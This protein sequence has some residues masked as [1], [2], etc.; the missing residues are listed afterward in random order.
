MKQD[1]HANRVRLGENVLVKPER[2][3]GCEQASHRPSTYTL[4]KDR[5]LVGVATKC[6][7]VV[8]DP[9]Q[10]GGLIPGC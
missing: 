8:A 5:N 1:L 2:S 6:S 10:C 7:N 3:E 4:S 9:M